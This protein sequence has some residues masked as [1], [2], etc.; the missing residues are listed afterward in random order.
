MS[1]QEIPNDDI[2]DVYELS[3]E[4][5]CKMNEILNE[6]QLDICMSAMICATINTI[7]KQCETK[8]EMNLYK[9]TFNEIFHNHL[10]KL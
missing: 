3:Q 7:I 5:E 6:N 2:R 4:L 10:N 9:K 8:E 1:S